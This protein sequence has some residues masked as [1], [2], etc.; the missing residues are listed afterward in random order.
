MALDFKYG[1][2]RVEID[3]VKKIALRNKKF[4]TNSFA[5]IR[6]QRPPICCI[7]TPRPPICSIA[8][9]RPRPRLDPAIL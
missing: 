5:Q 3:F 4:N 7:A 9:P 8:R 1:F 6:A 2:A